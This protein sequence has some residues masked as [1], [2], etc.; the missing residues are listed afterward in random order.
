MR[1][2]CKKWLATL[3]ACLL[4][5]A[6]LAGQAAAH[7]TAG[8]AGELNFVG[9]NYE[10]SKHPLSETTVTIIH[11]THFHGNFYTEKDP[12]NIA[13]YFGLI[14][15]IRAKQPNSLVIANGDDTA[16]SL[17]STVFM[18]QHMIDVFNAMK[19]DVDTFGNHDF[20]MGPEQLK[21]LVAASTFPWVSANVTDKNGKTFAEAEGAK[22]F[23]IKEV[24][25]VKIGLTGLT[26]EETPA[27]SDVGDNIVGDPVA[28]MKKIVPQMKQAGAE[29]IIVSSHLASPEAR[30][31]A[32]E[33]DGIDL[34]VG[35]H[36]AFAYEMPEKINDTLLWFIGDEF[37]YLG[38]INLQVK[39][40]KINDFNYHRY[41]L[42]DEVKKAEF[43]PDPKV[44]QIMDDYNGRL[45]KELDVVIGKTE[46][47][48]DI[49]KATQRKGETPIGNY[50][51]DAVRKYIQS[52]VAIVGGG[53]IRADY[54]LPPGQITKRNIMETLPFQNYLVKLEVSGEDLWNALENGV[55]ELES[56]AGRFPQVSG[57]QFS[58]NPKLAKGFRLVEVKV[59]G[60]PLDKRAT[61]TLGTTDYLAGGGDGYE[62][63]P[64]A[65]VLVDGHAGPLISL[66]VMD[67]VQQQGTI[68]PKAEQRI[69]VTDRKPSGYPDFA[70]ID[71]HEFAASIV[72]LYAKGIMKGESAARFGPD[73]QITRAE[74]AA[75]LTRVLG[76]SAEPEQSA[77]LP[78]KDVATG[79][80]Y[81]TAVREAYQQGL[82]QG[83]EG[84]R[85]APMSPITKEQVQIM[86]TNALKKQK[87]DA[88]ADALMEP[89]KNVAAT[90][91]MTRAQA[92]AAL[93]S[94]IRLLES[95]EPVANL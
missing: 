5:V 17:L 31:V 26:T 41:T 67:N 32:K 62:M 3:T 73:E 86:L 13:N 54:V 44:K 91:K 12:K 14:Q 42:E 20:D 30:I 64:K 9:E 16:T 72:K 19:V 33:V 34:I 55:S 47:E 10:M 8:S 23:I 93:D 74:F 94:F 38:Q 70:D 57:I 90:D 48:L 60:K 95:K 36:A 1:I 83:V 77:K 4:M 25:G 56:G 52:D 40:G 59:G 84:D 46:T 82:I 79:D 92:A 76:V 18:G 78:F 27:I 89:L 7:P 85:F 71:G 11:D 22:S 39:D 58:Y 51:A 53:D 43:K 28:A 15:Q 45:D 61:Y 69:T 35:D 29:I 6:A 88:A 24:N 80:W 66:L 87:V 81:Y 21:K 75:L 68:A 50:V 63:L 65:K 2:T 37:T 49:M